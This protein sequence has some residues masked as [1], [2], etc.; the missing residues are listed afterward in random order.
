MQTLL[1]SEDFSFRDDVSESVALLVQF[2]L[3]KS[4]LNSAIM[5]KCGYL[6]LVF[7]VQMLDRF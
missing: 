4:F 5:S 2:R 3:V 6:A 1:S 7:W